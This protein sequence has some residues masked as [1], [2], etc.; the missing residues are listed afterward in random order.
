MAHRDR[1]L[2]VLVCYGYLNE[3]MRIREALRLNR[4][5][6]SGSPLRRSAVTVALLQPV[7][8]VVSRSLTMEVSE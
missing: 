3:W 6:P 7:T 5:I 2:D 4:Q 8:P 1:G